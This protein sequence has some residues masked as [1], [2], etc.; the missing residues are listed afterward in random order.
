LVKPN[1]NVLLKIDVQG[2]ERNVLE[3]AKESLKKIIGVQVEMSVIGMYEGELTYLEMIDYLAQYGFVL[4]SF[5]NGFFNND[6]GQL[7]QVDGIFFKK[8]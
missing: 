6:T 8:E 7:Y 5:E 2:F 3:G 4:Y 1:D